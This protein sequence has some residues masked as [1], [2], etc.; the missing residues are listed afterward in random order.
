VIAELH[1]NIAAT[2]QC[3]CPPPRIWSKVY[4]VK[5]QITVCF[6]ACRSDETN[7]ITR[8]FVEITLYRVLCTQIMF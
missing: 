5:C 1:V 3:R 6:T 8:R 2:A 4:K 7:F